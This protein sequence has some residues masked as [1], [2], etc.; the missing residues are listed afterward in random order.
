MEFIVFCLPGMC[1]SSLDILEFSAEE[2][3]HY[4]SCGIVIKLHNIC[5]TYAACVF[6]D[7]RMS[8]W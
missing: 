6:V 8:L 2:Q 4:E 1:K 5:V 7:V 3:P